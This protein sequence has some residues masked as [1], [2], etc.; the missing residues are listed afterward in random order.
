MI[1]T[2]RATFRSL[3]YFNFRLWFASALVSNIGTWMQRIAQYW[4]VLTQLTHHD[5]TAVGFVSALQFGPQVLLLPW[6]GQATDRFD[7]RK[8]L[9]VT[10]AVMASL[11]LVLGG[12]V[13]TQTVQLW[14]VYLLALVQGVAIAFDSP[15]RQTFVADMVGETDLSNAIALNS[16]VNN[17]SRMIGPAV[18]GLVIASIGTGWAFVANG[19]S[20]AAVL[21][22]LTLMRR[23]D[24]LQVHAPEGDRRLLEGVTYIW[25]RPDLRIA[26]V[27]VFV[28]GTFA[29]NLPIFISTMAVGAFHAGP[30]GYGLLTSALA[31][32]AVAGAVVSARIETPR[33]RLLVGAAAA[34]AAGLAIASVL[35]TYVGFGVCLAF[36]GVASQIFT[37]A[38]N[39]L[40]QMSTA[41][42]VRGRVVA[43]LLVALQ[44]GTPI[45]APLVGWVAN[46]AGPR[47]GIGL[48]AA[49][50][51]LAALVGGWH[52]FKAHRSA[53]VTV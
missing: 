33:L 42:A 44:G 29:F 24:L 5:A 25:R 23:G 45:G 1:P 40:V 13:V 26:F 2:G 34:I 32:G 53:P 9:I 36:V 6:T 50:A 48:A 3:A 14:H 37:T 27:M 12:L 21:V 16:A 7:R 41:P 52:L 30:S 28:L 10:Q 47:W 46:I 20:F 31:V 49:A 4:L 18:A 11:A 43:L 19:A 17:V 39:G 22:A 35:P 38:C 8:I 15:A 51:V